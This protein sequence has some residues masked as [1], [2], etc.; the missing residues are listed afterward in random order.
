ML[1]V[2]HATDRPEALPMRAKFYR[3]HRTHLDEAPKQGVS[4]V[5]AGPLV[6][7]DGETPNG[8]L[9][10]LEAPNRAAVDVFTRSDP[11]CVNGVWQTIDIHTFNKKRG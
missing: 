3:E 6:G 9:F 11:Y 2:I 8:S 4:V 1:Y 7:D 5:M 10:I